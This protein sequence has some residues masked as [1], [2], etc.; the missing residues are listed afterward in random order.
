M[1]RKSMSQT[2]NPRIASPRNS[3]RSLEASR[4]N[5]PEAWVNGIARGTDP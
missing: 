5:A 4:C 2:T 3:S 1:L